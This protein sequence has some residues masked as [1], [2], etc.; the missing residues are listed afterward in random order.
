MQG[1]IAMC[2]NLCVV[3]AVTGEYRPYGRGYNVLV[4]F[5]MNVIGQENWRRAAARTI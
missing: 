2:Q 4:G 5:T 3:D 1:G